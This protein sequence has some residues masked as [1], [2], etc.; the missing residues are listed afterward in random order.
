M[1]QIAIK[2]NHSL[3]QDVAVDR[4]KVF[5]G[6]PKNTLLSQVTELNVKWIAFECLYSFKIKN[7]SIKGRMSVFNDLIIVNSNIPFVFLPF[8]GQIERN[9]M[10]HAKKILK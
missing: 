10:E 8:K 1:P 6:S 3:G 2:I 9:A 4:V 5:L 7:I